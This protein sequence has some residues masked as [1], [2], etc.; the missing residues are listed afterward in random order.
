[1]AN[2]AL[3]A[4][5]NQLDLSLLDRSLLDDWIARAPAGFEIGLWDGPYPEA[6]MPGI[7]ALMEVMNQQPRGDL[8][9]ED[10]AWTPELV[11]QIEAAQLAG[12]GRRWTLYAR[13]TASGAFAGFTEILLNPQQPAIVQQGNTGVL[14][15][16]RKRGL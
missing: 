9:I 8:Q 11:R 15:Q 2:M 6:D 3:D 12:D 1:G 16:F 7:V 14:P 13:E 4:H 10:T 5:V